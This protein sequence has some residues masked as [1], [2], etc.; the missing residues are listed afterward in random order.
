[1]NTKS[2][3]LL[4]VGLLAAPLALL[5]K[6]PES[7]Y[8]ESYHG[9][10]GIPVPISVIMPEVSARYAGEQVMLEFVVDATG[11]PTLLTSVTPGVNA[12]L[13]TSLVSAVAQ[14]QFAPALV[15]GKAVARKVALPVMISDE[16]GLTTRF[17]LN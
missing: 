9:R 2:K 1:M 14:W 10:A 6:S 3:I 4:S 11:K 17:A 13:V 7:A 16:N 15:E 12:E 5:A 8:V